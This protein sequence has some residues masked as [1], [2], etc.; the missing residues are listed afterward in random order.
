MAAPRGGAVSRADLLEAGFTRGFIDGRREAGWLLPLG[1]GIY[2]VGHP[3]ESE[4]GILTA[5]LLATGPGSALAGESAAALWG[6]HRW[7]GPIEII[8]PESRRPADLHLERPGLRRPRRVRVRRTRRI[9]TDE[10]SI[11]RG[12]RVTGVERTLVDLAG[13]RDA[14]GLRSAFNEADRLGLLRQDRLLTCAQRSRGRPGASDFRRLVET[15]HPE[16]ARNESELETRFMDLCRQNS[17]PLPESNPLL[18][19]YR[20]DCLWREQRLVVEL[21]GYEF[22]RG[23]M[24]F[25]KDAER[26]AELGLAGYRT[27]RLT[28]DMVFRQPGRTVRLIESHLR[29]ETNRD[30]TG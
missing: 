25:L 23:R 26:D 19:G 20:V 29:P 6:I 5:A 11:H 7:R 22:H 8:R 14:R 2:A 3:L 27:V 18:C 4:H 30:H 10:F 9:S 17:L 21:D 24:A 28:H 13:R 12:L 16:T 15:R 1:R